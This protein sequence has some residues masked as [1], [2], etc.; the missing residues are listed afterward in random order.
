MWARVVWLSI[1][2]IK[3]GVW[4][5]L[6]GRCLSSY[7]CASVTE[8][9]SASIPLSVTNS[10]VWSAKLSCPPK[11]SGKTLVQQQKRRDTSLHRKFQPISAWLN[12]TSYIFESSQIKTV[13]EQHQLWSNIM[14]N[15]V[16][17][18]IMALSRPVHIPSSLSA[19]AQTVSGT[20]WFPSLYCVPKDSIPQRT[21]SS[22]SLFSQGK[23]RHI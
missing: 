23:G 20:L 18:R 16:E 3:I 7:Q 19:S 8:I 15:C 14:E 21:L 9:M 12:S 6:S 22:V 13:V 2:C 17:G 1:L 5:P 11:A 10:P 4:P